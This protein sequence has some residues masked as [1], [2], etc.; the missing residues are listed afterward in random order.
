MASE[1]HEHR[2]AGRPGALARGAQAR[3]AAP[4]ARAPSARAVRRAGSHLLH[5]TLLHMV[6]PLGEF[7]QSQGMVLHVAVNQMFQDALERLRPNFSKCFHIQY[8][9]LE[10]REGMCVSALRT[11]KDESAGD[12]HIIACFL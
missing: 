11:G 5:G 9:P 10:R 2:P 3:R 12:L 4:A 7:G 1:W 6:V 8:T